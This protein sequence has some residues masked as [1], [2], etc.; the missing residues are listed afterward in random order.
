MHPWLDESWRRSAL[1]WI[2]GALAERGLSLT[3]AVEQRHVRV[4][5]TAM[6]V[7]T[8]G[9]VHWFK[10]NV[11]GCAYEAA[12]LPVLAA[13]APGQVLAPLAVDVGRGWFLCPDGGRTLR[14]VFESGLDLARWEEVL[15]RYGHFQRHLTPY[16][17]E[18]LAVGVPDN[19]PEKLPDHLA[20][21]LADRPV[22]LIDQPNGITTEQRDRVS[23]LQPEVADWCAELASAGIAPTI[24]HDDLQDANVLVGGGGYRFFDW[25]DSSVSHP[26]GSL[27]IPLRSIAHKFE[28]APGSPELYRIRDAYL[29]AW[30]GDHDRA[31]LI[32]ASELAYRLALIGRA[33]AWRRALD[34]VDPV[35]RVDFEDAVPASLAMLLEPS[36]P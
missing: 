24:Q 21:L 36:L 30:S 1:A 33:L 26:F 10:A 9:G 7:P 29:D 4:W 28:L 23:A 13:R 15:T 34:G 16:A 5:S 25:A 8:S 19:R 22:L 20:E 27:L 31:T 12:M 18:L 3:G 35:G 2:D 32:R 17:D 11:A 6:R 14:T